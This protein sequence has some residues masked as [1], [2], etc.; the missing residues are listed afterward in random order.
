MLFDALLDKTPGAAVRFPFTLPLA[1]AGFA[2]RLNWPKL[3]IH[4]RLK[5]HPNVK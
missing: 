2:I 3:S 5:A 1:R 4:V